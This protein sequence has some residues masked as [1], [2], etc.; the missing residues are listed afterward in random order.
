MFSR[1]LRLST[2]ISIRIP[3][4]LKK[5]LDELKDVVDWKKEIINFL[6]ERVKIYKK[7]K[8]LNEIH[9]ILENHPLVPENYG[10][11]SMREDR[12]SN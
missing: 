11:G 3:K 4:K 6:E 10:S 5:E 2:V 12:D 1:C 8:V 9:R 7:I